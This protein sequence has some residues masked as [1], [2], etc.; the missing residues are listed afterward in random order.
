MRTRRSHKNQDRLFNALFQKPEAIKPTETK[1]RCWECAAY[2]TGGRTRGK[3]AFFDEVVPGAS[4]KE[5]FR[6]REEG[7]NTCKAGKHYCN[8]VHTIDGEC[9]GCVRDERDLLKALLDRVHNEM[10][11]SGY[12]EGGET[13]QDSFEKKLRGDVAEAIGRAF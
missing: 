6:Q 8:E 11:V 9:P 1:A 2:P 13:E 4:I 5:C 12:G 7:M 10:A 3:C